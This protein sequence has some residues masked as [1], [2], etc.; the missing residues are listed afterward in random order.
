MHERETYYP[1]RYRATTP[2]YWEIGRATMNISEL[3]THDNIYFYQVIS[4]AFADS[5]HSWLRSLFC[6]DSD[7]PSS[8]SSPASYRMLNF[9]V[10]NLSI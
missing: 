9:W 10:L 1:L 8:R 7:Q 2:G 4:A 5:E 3:F 6:C